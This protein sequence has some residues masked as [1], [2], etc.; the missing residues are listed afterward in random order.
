MTEPLSLA[1]LAA[2]IGGEIL[3]DISDSP[4]TGVSTLKDAGPDQICYYGN[5]KY[6]S[7]LMTTAALA[8]ITG[9]P[10]ETSARC[11]IIVPEAYEGFRRALEL[12]KPDRA[13]GFDGIHSSSV[14][15]SSAAIGREVRIG[16]CA[17]V[18]SGCFIGA[19]TVIGAGSVL[20]RGVTL[21]ENCVIHSNVS[22]LAETVVGSGTII[23][24]GTVVGSDGF[25]FVPFADGKHRKVPQNG[26]VVIGSFV[27]IGSNC[28]IDRAV[29]GSTEIGDFTKLD[30]LIQVA[31]NVRI[32]RGCMIAA[33]T[34]IAGS[35]VIGDGVV[36]GGQVGVGGHLIIGNR[37]TV[38]AK[39]GVT[40]NIPDG[41]TVSG[42]PCRP[43]GE[44]LRIGAAA[45]RLP[46]IIGKLEDMAA[47]IA[48]ETED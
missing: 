47:K 8:V 2:A 41:V 32:G 48:E 5:R 31:H 17:V 10:V 27:E 25:G 16:P 4:V 24:S 30:N 21:G 7:Q 13:N 20:G 28:S 19:G 39:S 3:G 12:F 45:S 9:K 18:S 14:V 37:V 35:T 22:L 23:H 11:Q 40:K 15:H 38:G 33:Q 1:E 43:H 36:F 34:G 26:N 6:A 42:N 29:T 44:S 46:K